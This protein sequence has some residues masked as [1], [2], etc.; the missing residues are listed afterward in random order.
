MHTPACWF[1]ST[2]KYICS[3]THT[4]VHVQIHERRSA[5]THAP[6]GSH[7]HLHMYTCTHMYRLTH[8]HIPTHAHSL[9]VLHIPHLFYIY[10]DFQCI[11]TCMFSFFQVRRNFN[12]WKLLS[13]KL[14]VKFYFM[15]YC[16][17]IYLFVFCINFKISLPLLNIFLFL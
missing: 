8:A 5:H 1:L 2:H 12:L 10:L 4:R 7:I 3:F 9:K 14:V 15:I 16:L 17:C 13:G 6:M 11:M